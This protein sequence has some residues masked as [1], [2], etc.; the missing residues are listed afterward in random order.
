MTREIS[1]SDTI[2]L[3]KRPVSVPLFWIGILAFWFLLCITSLRN[4]SV[5]DFLCT[6]NDIV[7]LLN[8]A[9]P[10]KNWW[11][12]IKLFVVKN[13]LVRKVCTKHCACLF[14]SGLSEA[15]DFLICKP[16]NQ[17]SS[18]GILWLPLIIK[19]LLFCNALVLFQRL[20][21]TLKWW[22]KERNN[23]SFL[24]LF[25][26]SDWSEN[27]DNELVWLEL[28]IIHVLRTFWLAYEQNRI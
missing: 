8:Q 23:F 21:Q 14:L 26:M 10:G 2:R 22:K 11:N 16:F 4:G 19:H 1:H 20:E 25:E 9:V 15:V 27:C 13:D 28:V 18:G 17:R 24:F 5:Y 3:L 7:L 12:A 6:S